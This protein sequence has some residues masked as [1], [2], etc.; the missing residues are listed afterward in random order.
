LRHRWGHG[1]SG[2]CRPGNGHGRG[3]CRGLSNR[4]RHGRGSRRRRCTSCRRRYRSRLSHRRS[5]RW[6]CCRSRRIG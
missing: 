2:C 1:R 6:A 5:D 4:R 3:C